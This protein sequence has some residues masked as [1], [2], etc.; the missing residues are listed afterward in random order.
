MV[1]GYYYPNSQ[2]PQELNLFR[3]IREIAA[4][5]YHYTS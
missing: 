4:C 2:G 5:N 3:V 1:S